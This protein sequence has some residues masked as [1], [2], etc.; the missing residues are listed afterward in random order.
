MCLNW[1]GDIYSGSCKITDEFVRIGAENGLCTSVTKAWRRML[2]E[3]FKSRHGREPS[4]CRLSVTKNHY[5]EARLGRKKECVRDKY[6]V[7]Y[8]NDSED[9][10]RFSKYLS[11]GDDCFDQIEFY[12]G[13]NHPIKRFR[14]EWIDIDRM[15]KEKNIVMKYKDGTIVETANYE[16]RI[17]FGHPISALY[18][19]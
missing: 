8:R 15:D 17:L 5:R 14:A 1:G 16:F 7:E 18:S 6:Q 2:D 12:N 11:E 3:E 10:S 13:Y 9:R 19:P 4:V